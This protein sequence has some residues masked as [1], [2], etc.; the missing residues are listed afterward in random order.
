MTEMKRF[1]VGGQPLAT[2]TVG[3]GAGASNDELLRARFGS[4][5]N[6]RKKQRYSVYDTT[7][8][9]DFV[10]SHADW[11]SAYERI[12]TIGGKG[13]PKGQILL[14][15]AIWVE[16]GMG[17]TTKKIVAVM[18]K[19]SSGV[20]SHLLSSYSFG[21][22]AAFADTS[23]TLMIKPPSTPGATLSQGF[24][25]DPGTVKNTEFILP[26]VSDYV[27]PDDYWLLQIGPNPTS[28]TGPLWGKTIVTL[29]WAELHN[30]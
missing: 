9:F 27:A 7:T 13:G 24:S 8:T 6:L 29:R 1:P 22:N 2:E 4:I 14:R 21:S 3:T 10:G 17:N 25:T 18:G 5:D 20:P 26:I 12:R 11:S 16:Q 23:T 15:A 19:S 30:A 28:T